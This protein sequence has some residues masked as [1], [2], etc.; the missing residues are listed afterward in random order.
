M[1]NSNISNI[2]YISISNSINNS[3]ILY[4]IYSIL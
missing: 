2:I 3:N 1:C 4:I